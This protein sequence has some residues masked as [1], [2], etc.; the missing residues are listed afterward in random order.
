M[1][2]NTELVRGLYEAFA[3][4]DVGH[5]VGSLEENVDWQEAEGFLY[6]D[7]NPYRSP[8]SVLEGVFMRIGADFDNFTV[9][10]QRIHDAGETVIVEGR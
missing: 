10:P 6:D 4:G 9:T 1:S 3:R 5:V 8:Q 2:A 7:Q